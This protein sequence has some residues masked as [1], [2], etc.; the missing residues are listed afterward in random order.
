MTKE[1]PQGPVMTTTPGV[2]VAE[3][4]NSLTAGAHGPVAANSPGSR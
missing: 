3:N 4:Q 2:P 1:K